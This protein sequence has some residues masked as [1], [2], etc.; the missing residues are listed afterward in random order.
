MFQLVKSSSKLT[1]RRK[2]ILVAIFIHEAVVSYSRV[3]G[4]FTK[5]NFNGRTSVCCKKLR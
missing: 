3:D 1:K 2:S 5:R 4:K